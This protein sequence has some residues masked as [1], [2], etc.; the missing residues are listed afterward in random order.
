MAFEGGAIVDWLMCQLFQ[1][2]ASSWKVNLESFMIR[3]MPLISCKSIHVRKVAAAY[4]TVLRPG[5]TIRLFY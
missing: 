4:V 3:T 2:V 1:C 5:L